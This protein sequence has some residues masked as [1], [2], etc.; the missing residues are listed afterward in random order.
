MQTECHSLG[1]QPHSQQHWP[2]L[3]IRGS[4]FHWVGWHMGGHVIPIAAGMTKRN[5]ILIAGK[6]DE[7]TK[8]LLG[9]ALHC[10]PE[11]LNMPIAL[12]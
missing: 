9:E 1:P 2:T 6:F 5:P 8:L 3:T 7:S 4:N 10:S 11:E 12:N